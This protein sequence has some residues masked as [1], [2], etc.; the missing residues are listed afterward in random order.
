MAITADGQLFVWGYNSYGDLGLG[1][2]KVYR[3]PTAVPGLTNV[4]SVAAGE[5][6]KPC[7]C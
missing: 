5:D 7:Y 4:I 2:T 6:H 1:D 3:T